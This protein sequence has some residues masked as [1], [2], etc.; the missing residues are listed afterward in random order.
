MVFEYCK[1]FFE[2]GS[3]VCIVLFGKYFK[4]AYH[5]GKDVVFL[6]IELK[7]KCAAFVRLN[8]IIHCFELA[9]ESKNSLFGFIM[10]LILADF[11]INFSE[12]GFHSGN[13]L[14]LDLS[15]F[16]SIVLVI[17]PFEPLGLL[18]FEGSK[19]YSDHV[20]GLLVFTLNA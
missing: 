7:L 5:H 19:K 8:R 13:I 18:L 10:N 9:N 12:C 16:L 2:F 15:Q 1:K 20:V 4:S 3:L 14:R 6:F 17:V 11:R